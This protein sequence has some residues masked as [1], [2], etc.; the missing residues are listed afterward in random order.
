MRNAI[1]ILKSEHRSLASDATGVNI[2]IDT[3]L[4]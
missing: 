2:V 1:S 3:V 4:R